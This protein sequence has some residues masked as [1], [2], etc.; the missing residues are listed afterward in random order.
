MSD[1]FVRSHLKMRHLILLV[2]LGRHASIANAAAAAR[3]TQPSASRL[4]SDLEH[5]LGIQLF[6]RMARGVVPTWAGKM[7]IRRAGVALAEMDAAHFE[8]STL[9][10][11]IGGRVAIGSVLTPATNILMQAIKLFKARSQ[12]ASLVVDFSTSKSMVERLLDGQLDM[13]L[14][15]I[16]DTSTV[17]LLNFEP[18]TDEVHHLIVR[19]THPLVGRADLQLAELVE[20]SWIV[21]P[22]GSILRDR[23]TALFLSEGLDPPVETVETL[24]VP[25]VVSLVTN[26]DMLVALPKE[27]VQAQLAAGELVALPFDLKLRMDVYG[28][29][30]RQGHVLSPGAE[31]MVD[32]LREA[33]AVELAA[34]RKLRQVP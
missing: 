32:A 25:L 21:P 7:L 16:L 8:I 15:R 3:L 17:P 10:S 34:S 13:V 20:Q 6:E 5:V 11:G 30:T 24:S 2:E 33:A 29:I 14:G 28:I 22:A 19:A 4:I 23:L 12:K 27:L 31:I 18:I 1:R 26:T 9:L